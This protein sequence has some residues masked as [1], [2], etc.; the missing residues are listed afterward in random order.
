MDRIDVASGR[1]AIRDLY[2]LD[3]PQATLH[4]T[5][6]NYRVWSTE[7]D[8]R[9]NPKAPLF[10]PAYLSIQ[11]SDTAPK[12]VASPDD[13]YAEPVPPYGIS[14]WV[15]LGMILVHDAE[16]LLSADDM[17][18]L[19]MD[20]EAAWE[21]DRDYSEIFTTAK[22]KIITCKTVVEKIRCPIVASYDASGR[23]VAIH[24]D[25]TVLA[26]VQASLR[27]SESRV[28]R[29]GALTG[30]MFPWLFRSR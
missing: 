18:A 13:L 7:I 15:D 22:A 4:I 25:F 29:L 30:R 20:W 24:V 6:G 28:Q 14:V 3:R 2:D 19:E 11:L 26:A 1:L 9:T 17:E 23:P 8:V 5:P 12:R 21:S 27:A 10:R 16:S